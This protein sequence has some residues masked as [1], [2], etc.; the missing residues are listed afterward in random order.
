LATIAQKAQTG[1]KQKSPAKYNIPSPVEGIMKNN[2]NLEGI[3]KTNK[4][5]DGTIN[6]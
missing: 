3:M 4:N 2:K 5:L 6:K 1:E